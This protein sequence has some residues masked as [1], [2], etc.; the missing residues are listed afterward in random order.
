MNNFLKLVLT[1]IIYYAIFYLVKNLTRKRVKKMKEFG[2]RIYEHLITKRK[3]NKLQIKLD[4]KTEEYDKKVIELN[5]ER[6]KNKIQQEVW[7][8]NLKE[9]EETIVELKKKLNTKKSK[10]KESGKDEKEE[11]NTR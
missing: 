1:I 2:S 9:Q 5:Q 4:V 6:R 11:N 3:Y 10:K 8:R 7:E